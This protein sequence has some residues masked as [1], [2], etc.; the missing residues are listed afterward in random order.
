VV[1]K[2]EFICPE[3]FRMITAA[4]MDYHEPDPEAFS[5]V[6]TNAFQFYIPE[7]NISCYTYVLTRPN[8]GVCHSSIYL[9]KGFCESAADALWADAR[10]HLPCPK[11]LLDFDLPNGFGTTV[12]NGPNDYHVRYNSND[13]A[14]KFDFTY[15]ALVGPYDPHDA[16]Q[17]PLRRLAPDSTAAGGWGEAWSNGHFDMLGE[18][19]GT[20][21]FDGKTYPIDCIEAMDHTWGP[22]PE[23]EMGSISWGNMSF[24]PD[25]AFH[26]L[27]P[28]ELDEAGNSIHQPL[29]FGHMCDN[30]K[31]VGLVSAQFKTEKRGPFGIRQHITVVDALGRSWEM[32]GEAVGYAPWHTS[33]PSFLIYS[34]LYRWTMGDRVGQSHVM[35]VN[36]T[37]TL[38]RRARAQRL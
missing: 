35:E 28:F 20:L 31:I 34:S 9:H 29:T 21:I 24:G 10:M 5:W 27:C 1:G 4:D 26:V 23:W 7:E 14:C 13:G 2:F 11:S 37:G 30:G 6:E 18:C 38:G 33:Y 3:S 25:L 15:K 22:R 36:G 32:V 8:A 16:D 12:L 19:K 17:N